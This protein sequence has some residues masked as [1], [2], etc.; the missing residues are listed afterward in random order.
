[1]SEHGAPRGGHVL[2][3]GFEP[4]GADTQNPSRELAKALDGRVIGGLSVRGLVLPVG[5]IKEKVLAAH[6]SGMR[7]VILPAENRKDLIEIP[8]EVRGEIEFVFVDKID[9][10]LMEA[11]TDLADRQDALISPA[12]IAS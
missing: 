9:D 11:I 8:E 6:R 4:F 2:L 10:V 12:A 3:T 1:M 7:R 5:G